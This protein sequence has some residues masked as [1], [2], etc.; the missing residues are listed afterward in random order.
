VRL[1]DAVHPDDK[2]AAGLCEFDPRVGRARVRLFAPACAGL[3]DTGLVGLIAHLFGQV[4]E[5][6][7]NGDWAETEGEN[8]EVNANRYAVYWGFEGELRAYYHELGFAP[9]EIPIDAEA[10][11]PE[12]TGEYLRRRQVLSAMRSTR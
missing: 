3:S 5:R 2:N 8:I 1:E 10:M 11:D 9:A 6:Y 12:R 7:E 4:E